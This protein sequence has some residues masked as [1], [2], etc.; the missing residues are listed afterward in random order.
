MQHPPREETGRSTSG[1]EMARP[2]VRKVRIGERLRD[3]V[4]NLIARYSARLR[5]DPLVP[6]ARSLAAPLI[7]DHAMS[8][9]SDVFQ[10]LVILE[11]AD[12]L[13]GREETEL[14]SDG[15]RIQRLV[16]ELHGRQRRR[17]GWTETALQ[18][19]YQILNDEVESFV[20]RHAADEARA[21]GLEWTLDIVSRLLRHAQEASFAA[22]GAAAQEDGR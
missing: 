16:A 20:K 14:L 19:E 22:Y 2:K 12:Q 21:G 5:N 9:L 18:R 11:S 1:E 4:E 7:E 3:N 10:A 8:F 17:L 15:T 13:K 6:A